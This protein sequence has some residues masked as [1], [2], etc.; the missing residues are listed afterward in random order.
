MTDNNCYE[1][2]TL[3]RE[4][5]SSD[6]I[7]LSC[8]EPIISDILEYKIDIKVVKCKIIKNCSGNKLIIEG[9]KILKICYASKSCCGKIFVKK[10]TIPFFES[11]TLPSCV[12]SISVKIVPSYCD[13]YLLTCTSFVVNSTLTFCIKLSF[14]TIVPKVTCDCLC[15]D[16]CEGD[17]NFKNDCYPNNYVTPFKPIYSNSNKCCKKKVNECNCECDI[18]ICCENNCIDISC[19]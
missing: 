3:I 13:L 12:S 8:D 18:D 11:I 17:W 19:N 5:S 16:K 10:F 15:D 1:V 4:S 7:E 6:K 14:K 9:F 2:K